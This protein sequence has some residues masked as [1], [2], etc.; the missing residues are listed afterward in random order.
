M[1]YGPYSDY[2]GLTH[3]RQSSRRKVLA[4]GEEDGR[5]RGNSEDAVVNISWVALRG[6]GE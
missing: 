5:L 6:C 2:I 1:G 4:E 3:S